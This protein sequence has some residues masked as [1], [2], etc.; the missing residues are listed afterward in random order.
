M[1]RRVT[2]T[3]SLL[4]RLELTDSYVYMHTQA[5]TTLGPSLHA[6]GGGGG[7]GGY[8]QHSQ[9]QQQQA[10]FE[11][12]PGL[13]NLGNTCYLNSVLQVRLC[14]SLFYIDS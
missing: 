1:A 3:P 4:F 13:N 10:R 8:R 6:N 2:L 14:G 5:G 11:V 7:G 12:G 9:Q